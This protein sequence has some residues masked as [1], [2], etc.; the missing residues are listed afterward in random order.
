MRTYMAPG[1][2]VVS[3]AVAMAVGVYAVAVIDGITGRLVAGAGRTGISVVLD[4]LR[5]VAVL[6]MQ[7]RHRTERADAA[8]WR[9]RRHFSVGSPQRHLPS[10]P[11]NAARRWPTPAPGSWSSPLRS[12]S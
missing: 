7:R 3:V 8:G 9:W 12:G 6:L 1:V 11:S 2:A 4:P 5:T 10:F